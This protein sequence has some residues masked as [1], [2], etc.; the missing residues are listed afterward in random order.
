MAASRSCDHLGAV[1]MLFGSILCSVFLTPGLHAL[2]C[3][4]EYLHTING[5]RYWS[6]VTHGQFIINEASSTCSGEG[7]PQRV[8]MKDLGAV[9]CRAEVVLFSDDFESGDVTAWTSVAQ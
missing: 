2:E 8:T 5:V 3:K 9:V 6:E 7:H 4:A 1:R